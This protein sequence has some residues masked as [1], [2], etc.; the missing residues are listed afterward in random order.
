MYCENVV[1]R[2]IAFKN[3]P[4]A[5]NTD[6]LDLDSCRNVRIADCSFDVGD[7]CL[8][9][10]SGMDADGR[11]VGKPTENVNITNCTMLHGHGG[12]HRR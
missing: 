11:R 9:L 12:G 8:C 6:G 5:P 2:G 10:K 7:D 3:P 4:N 1:I